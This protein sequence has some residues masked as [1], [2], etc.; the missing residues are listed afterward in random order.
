MDATTGGEDGGAA[1][2]RPVARQLRWLLPL[3]VALLVAA[4]ALYEYAGPPAAARRVYVSTIQLRL[5]VPL[6]GARS[7][8]DGY[9]ARQT[10]D[11]A[12]RAFASGAELQSQALD[13]AIASQYA[14]GHAQL[15]QI[16]LRA[17]IPQRI[18]APEVGTA[19][20]ASH[21]GNLVTL[22]AR[23]PTPQGARALL[24]ATVQTLGMDG[25]PMSTAAAGQQG[26][27]A[28][29]A[30]VVRIQSQ[31]PATFASLDT[32]VQASALATLW[33]RLT[34]AVAAG[35]A[36]LLAL[37]WVAARRGRG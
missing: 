2:W 35:L 13:N 5:G 16:A 9:L 33:T 28:R 19:L 11:A 30:V 26:H 22:A 12:A 29:P 24:V 8:Y 36:T 32:A 21:A 14:A 15:P 34:F 23:W 10:E 18:S 3:A 20:S 4:G 25:V 1:Q 7:T 31:G 6:P 17:G 27:A 37:L